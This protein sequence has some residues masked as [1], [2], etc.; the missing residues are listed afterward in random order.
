MFEWKNNAYVEALM[1]SFSLYPAAT[2]SNIDRTLEKEVTIL[3]VSRY[4]LFDH[5][6]RLDGISCTSQKISH[7]KIHHKHIGK[8]TFKCKV[9]SFYASLGFIFCFWY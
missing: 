6:M 4:A 1:K 9:E 8:T 7:P 3:I 5:E 2:P